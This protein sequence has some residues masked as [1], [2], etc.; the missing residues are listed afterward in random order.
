MDLKPTLNF[1]ADLAKNNNRDWFQEHKKTYDASKKSVLEII[2]N[3]IDEI[4]KFDP[5]LDGV[6]A[7]SCLFRINRDIRFSKDKSP[8]KTNFGAL[9]GSAGKKT[10]GTGYYF[11]IMPGQNF[12]GG[13]IYMPPAE[14]L[15]AIRQE[16][17]Y[18]P[19]ALVKLIESKDFKDTFGKIQGEAL[20]TAPK[21][22]PKDHPHI[23]LLRFKSYYVLKEFTDKEVVADTF[24]K[25]AVKTLKKAYQF[26][27]YLN[28]AMD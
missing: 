14:K 10:E 3:L 17:D 12:I 8:Y 9:M 1:L 7:K 18:N 20:K 16:I 28:Q 19:D 22:Y 13:G 5:S 27:Q 15:A 23:E 25:E 21:G 4:A 26:N 24:T 6:E 11:H 2:Q